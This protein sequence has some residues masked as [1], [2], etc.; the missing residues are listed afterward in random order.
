LSLKVLIFVEAHVTW[1]YAECG[2][3]P[4]HKETREANTTQSPRVYAGDVTAS[5][6]RPRAWETYESARRGCYPSYVHTSVLIVPK[7]PTHPLDSNVDCGEV[8]EPKTKRVTI[9]QYRVISR[10]DHSSSMGKGNMDHA[11]CC[12]IKHRNAPEG[13]R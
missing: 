3:S 9:E 8:D 11:E 13:L 2:N 7:T 1:L 4:C 5:T 6:A 12:Y 10:P